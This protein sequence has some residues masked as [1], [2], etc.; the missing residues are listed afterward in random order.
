[1]RN[2]EWWKEL[3]ESLPKNHQIL[4]ALDGVD[5]YTHSRY[6]IGTD[7]NK[8][9]ENAKSFISAG[10]NATWN[11]LRFKHNQD[12]DKQAENLSKSLGF[13]Q[14]IIKDTRRF[15]SPTHPV[16][17]SKGNLLEPITIDKMNYV[18]KTVLDKSYNTWSNSKNIYCYPLDTKSIYIDAHFTLLPC[19]ILSSFLYTNYDELIL[20]KYNLYDEITSVNVMG[21]TIKNQVFDIVEEIGGFDSLNVKINGIK[22]IIENKKWQNIW[23]EKWNTSGSLTCLLMCSKESPFIPLRDQFTK[24]VTQ[25]N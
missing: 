3:A 16:L 10:G 6:R 4:F 24:K 19:C 17:D 25:N 1:L 5:Q 12:Q 22:N 21:K 7:F 23:H 13:S 14:F 9:I 2:P 18:D 20:K 11:F 15:T 8:I